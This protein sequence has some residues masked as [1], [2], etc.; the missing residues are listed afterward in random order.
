MA[1]QF[2]SLLSENI[3]T[4]DG[5]DEELRESLRRFGWNPKLPALKDEHGEVLV[6]HRRL[7]LAKELGISPVVKVLH[8]GEGDDADAERVKLALISNLGFK[9]MTKADR[10]RIAERL[11]GDK[12]W[13]MQR[14]A[15]ALGLRLEWRDHNVKEQDQEPDHCSSA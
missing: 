4:D 6:G 3:R 9:P 7:R 8:L 12:G 1:D 13:T 10:Q 5:D 15:E 14:I 2:R 11:Y